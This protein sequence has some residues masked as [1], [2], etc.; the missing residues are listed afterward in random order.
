MKRIIP[1]L[2]LASILFACKKDSSTDDS[3]LATAPRFPVGFSVLDF[4]TETQNMRIAA[5]SSLTKITDV[6][7]FAYGSDGILKSSIH[8]DTVNNKT[9]FGKINDSLPAGTYTIVINAGTAPIAI[10]GGTNLSSAALGGQIIN[11][12]MEPIPDVFFN[13]IQVT[14]NATGNPVL[15]DV[16][17]NRITGRIR[18]ELYDALPVADPNGEITLALSTVPILFSFNTA[19]INNQFPYFKDSRAGVR[20]DQTTLEANVLGSTRSFWAHI[21]Y[22]DKLGVSKSKAF[23]DLVL[24]ANKKTTIKG[25]LYG[26]PDTT[27]GDYELKVNSSFS[28]STVISFN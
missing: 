16:T 23:P 3:S 13:K 11:D 9:D 18:V 10:N 2:L 26:V 4:I 27:K 28:D 6:Y 24:T 19:S 15:Q 25:Y 20:L 17:L 5:D 7:Y 1:A 12:F 14:V 21:L 22:K 8:Q